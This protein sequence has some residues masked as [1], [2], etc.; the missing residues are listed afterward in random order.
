MLSIIRGIFNSIASYRLEDDEYPVD[1]HDYSSS[2]DRSL[3]ANP[4]YVKQRDTW[5]CG[6][7]CIKM[8]IKWNNINVDDDISVLSS[9]TISTYNSPLW[10]IDLYCY[11]R[12]HNYDA[13]MYT[14]TTDI[15]DIIAFHKGLDWYDEG[16]NDMI[17][18]NGNFMLAKNNNWMIIQ[19]AFHIDNVFIDCL[20]SDN[21]VAIVLVDSSTINSSAISDRNDTRYTGHYILV[22]AFDQDSLEAIYLDPAKDDLRQRVHVDV[23]NKARNHVGTDNDVIVCYKHHRDSQHHQVESPQDH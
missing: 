16:V 21:A 17:R 11:L 6:L 18:I 23:L 5:D 20:I 12:S 7:A 13:I 1:Y 3:T 22:I 19:D 4:Y 2:S 14:K 10:T 8:V 9:D 15:D